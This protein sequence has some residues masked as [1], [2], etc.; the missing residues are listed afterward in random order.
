METS[1]ADM[2]RTSAQPTSHRP[3][4]P[5]QPLGCLFFVLFLV[6][7]VRCFALTK[8]FSLSYWDSLF[9]DLSSFDGNVVFIFLDASLQN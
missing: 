8:E 6:L 5:N 7:E 4:R 9:G 2:P 1:L 3:Q